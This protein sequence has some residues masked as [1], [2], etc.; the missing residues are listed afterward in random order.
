MDANAINIVEYV[1]QMACLL[2]LQLDPEHRTAVI[3]NF[4][5]IKAIAQLV[6]EFPL[7]NHIEASPIFEP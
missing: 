7:P 6:N 5:T 2:D 3:E 1:D 4:T